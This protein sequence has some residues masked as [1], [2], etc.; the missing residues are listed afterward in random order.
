MKIALAQ[1]GMTRSIEDNL[2]TSLAM[3]ADAADS[4]A[5]MVVFPEIQFSPFFPQY[6]ASSSPLDAG[7]YAMRLD[8]P[9]IE[10]IRKAC[11]D[12]R[13]MACPNAYLMEPDGRRIDATLVIG[14]DGSLLGRQGMVH[15]AQAA[16][17]Y[18]QDYYA[19]DD[20][21]RV[22][23]TPFGTIGVCVCFDRHYPETIRTLALRG[24]DLVVIPTANT[25]AEP[26]EMFL[27]EVRVQAFQNSVNIAMCN[28]V[29]V[30]GAMS[31][32]GRSVIVGPDGK[33]LA[34]AGEKPCLLTADIDLDAAKAMRNDKPYTSLRRPELYA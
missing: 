4:H 5:D 20:A 2:K 22:I 15:I 18:E 25:S 26:E 12:R 7:G 10:A 28:R 17:F 34:L 23:A 32:D 19:P 16:C 6:P 33:V 9:A 13:I 27:Q 8:D 30:E 3:I 1:M 21:I 31:F 29:G 11:A 14:A 24:A